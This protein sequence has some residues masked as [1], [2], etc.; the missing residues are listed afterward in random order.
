MLQSQYTPTPKTGIQ[1]DVDSLPQASMLWRSVLAQAISDIY[2]GKPSHRNDVIHWLGEEDFNTVCDHAHVEPDQ[3]REQ[4][5]ALCRLPTP[6]A[7]KYG[8]MLRNFVMHGIH[9]ADP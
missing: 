2:S 3:M 7:K 4:I 6:L 9:K 5:A 1:G 8:K